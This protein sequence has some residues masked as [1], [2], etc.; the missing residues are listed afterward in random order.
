MNHV[1][2]TGPLSAKIAF[3]GEAPGE[4]EQAT[5]VPFHPK[6]PSGRELDRW[7]AIAGLTRDEVYIDNVVPIQP[8]KNNMSV[9]F[10]VSKQSKFS[11]GPRWDEFVKYVD[12]LKGRLEKCTCNVMVPLGRTALYALYGTMENSSPSISKLRGSV[13]TST[14]LPGRKIIATYHP[15]PKNQDPTKNFY[16]IQDVMRAARDSEY[17]ELRLPE[18]ALTTL[19]NADDINTVLLGFR[20]WEGP[21]AIDIE[22]LND[23]I[24]HIS[25]SSCSNQAYVIP[26]WTPY[27]N[28]WSLREERS[29]W[30]MVGAV[31]E[32]VPCVGQNIQFDAYFLW[33]KLGIRV[34]VAHDTMLA[35][36]IAFPGMDKD[37]GT[38]CSLFTREPYYKDD[39]GNFKVEPE[40]EA[41]FLRYS[42]LDAAVLH[43]ILPKVLAELKR[44]G[45]L[46]TYHETIRLIPAALYMQARGI[47]LDMPRRRA[48][49][50][51][52]RKLEEHTLRRLHSV[53]GAELNPNSHDHCVAY[54]HGEK[55]FVKHFGK[56]A[57]KKLEKP[58]IQVLLALSPK[59]KPVMKHKKLTMDAE[60]MEKM[61]A[62][63][64]QAAKV[65]VKARH[66]GKIRATFLEYLVLDG[67]SRSEMKV[68]GSVSGRFSSS[69]FLWGEGTNQQN[70]PAAVKA[71]W[72][73]D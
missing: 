18:R 13:L 12:E 27:Q 46:D 50:D 42:A 39:G 37:L 38:L 7:L 53:V 1:S 61:A 3:I 16:G 66:F 72:I 33:R 35:Y 11:K 64:V 45:N 58:E 34:N 30:H 8:P 49:A 14:L 59:V 6:A 43:D 31:L 57:A 68:G 20:H 28:V 25:L 71:C 29:I 19:R 55:E 56:M 44:Q 54:F 32:A 63:G 22:T 60:A 73:A 23:E 70:Q 4:I 41:K 69:A 17:P 36:H 67:R 9:F 21:L 24:S 48:M 65:I 15:S 5:G 26:F 2:P 47:R 52:Y 10:S 62:K 40:N 51:Y